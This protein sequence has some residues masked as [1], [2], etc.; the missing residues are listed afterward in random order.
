MV[1]IAR[2]MLR[3]S[4]KRRVAAYVIMVAAAPAVVVPASSDDRPFLRSM[5]APNELERRAAPQRPR[6]DEQQPRPSAQ[7]DAPPSPRRDSVMQEAIPPPVD[8]GDLAPVMADDGSGLPYEL[9]RGLNTEA[10]EGLI[11]TIE[12]PPRSPTL[13]GL[14]KR[15]IGAPSNAGSGGPA[16]MHFLALR[17]EVLYRSGLAREAAAELARSGGVQSPIISILEARNALAT[18]DG[19][20][21]CKKIGSVQP[22]G[23]DV[24][25]LLKGQA[26]LMSGY[27]AAVAGDTAGAG[28]AAELAR[29]EGL[30]ASPGLD[31]LDAMAIGAKP[32]YHAAKVV[33]L[34]DYRIAEKAGG[35]PHKMVLEHGEPALLAALASDSA[36]PVDLGLPATEAAA[37]LNALSPETL[38]AIYRVN[39]GT[40][41]TDGAS[42]RSKLLQ[43]AEAQSNPN[44]KARLIQAFIDDA[45]RDGLGFQAMQIMAQAAGSLRPDPSLAAFGPTAAEVGIA[46]GDYEMVRRWAAVG[47]GRLD[48]WAALAD[49]ADARSQDRGQSLAALER[50]ATTNRFSPD[51][52]NR[53]ATVLEA[54]DY[55]VPIPLWEAANRTPQ[56][57]GGYLPETGVLSQ[58]QDAA[59]KQE[60]GRTVLLTTKSLGPTGA[61]GANL[62]ALGDSIRALKRAGLEPDARKLAVEALLASWPR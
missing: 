22:G 50:M 12:I 56:P 29:E 47:G 28:L 16:D 1:G 17:I 6:Y 53:L 59:K 27:C 8:R 35:L 52:L 19:D 55:V 23:A 42:R 9:W 41:G 2:P 13:H 5:D 37:R 51:T 14:W 54:L 31:A 36:T 57:T 4:A 48:H 25:K 44:E 11:S 26:V 61:E 49:I 20:A 3:I 40:G 46:S 39:A 45:K 7:V 24:P 10:I 32:N 60:F 33:T 30:D 38:A 43:E 62:I 15:L 34:L 18:G 21:A 58:L